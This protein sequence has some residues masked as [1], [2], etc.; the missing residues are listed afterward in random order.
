VQ[1]GQPAQATF[2]FKASGGGNADAGRATE[3]PEAAEVVL[4][5][6]F[7]ATVPKLPGAPCCT[8]C[9]IGTVAGAVASATN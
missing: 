9:R 4:A 8:K 2:T 5:E 6:L 1:E 3:M 7:P